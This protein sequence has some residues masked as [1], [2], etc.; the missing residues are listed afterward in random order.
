MLVN[1]GLKDAR[2]LTDARVLVVLALVAGLSG[3]IAAVSS[4]LEPGVHAD[5]RSPAA[6]EYALPLTQAR[7][8]GSSRGDALFGAGIRRKPTMPAGSPNGSSGGL[9]STARQARR[10][11][12]GRGSSTSGVSRLAGR[13]SASEAANG[14]LPAAVE[15]AAHA[16]ASGSAGSLLALLGGGVAVLALGALGGTVLRG[17]RTLDSAER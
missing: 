15:S 6:K 14:S 12:D 9:G 8:T 17:R 13:P 11:M 4:A 3:G 5:P 10:R 2:A 7:R 1:V 16:R